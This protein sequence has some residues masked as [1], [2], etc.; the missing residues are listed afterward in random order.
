[1]IH[2]FIPS[3][4]ISAR[5]CTL[6]PLAPRKPLGAKAGPLAWASGVPPLRGMRQMVLSTESDTVS[7]TAYEVERLLFL[8]LGGKQLNKLF[9]LMHV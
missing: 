1:M 9:S 8:Y 3:L 4:S 6:I 5:E 2:L 7:S